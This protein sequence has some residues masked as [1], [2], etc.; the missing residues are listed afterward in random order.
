MVEI[1]VEISELLSKNTFWLFWVLRQ[2]R[3]GL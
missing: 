1:E 3:K 2:K